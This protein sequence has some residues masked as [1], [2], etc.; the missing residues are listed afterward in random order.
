MIM[1]ASTSPAF[2]FPHPTLT[3][4]NGKPTA[5]TIKQLTREVYANARSVHLT[6]G[7]GANG[8]LATCVTA[9]T[10][11]ARAGQPFDVPLHPG[12]QPVHTA[13]ATGPQITAMNRQYDQ[14]LR[15]F[16]T[17]QAVTESIFARSHPPYIL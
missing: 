6:R 4:L 14:D 2:T 17:H 9:A 5:A 3:P 8:H 7:G 11:L 12:P 10:Y 13:N 15:D 1:A 16:E